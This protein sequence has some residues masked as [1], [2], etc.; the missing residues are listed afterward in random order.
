M[1]AYYLRDQITIYI[2][3]KFEAVSLV[4]FFSDNRVIELHP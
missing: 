4:G 2:I 1:Y 3:C